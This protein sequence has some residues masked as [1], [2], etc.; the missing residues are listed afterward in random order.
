MIYADNVATTQL[1]KDA[2]DAMIPFMTRSMGMHRNHTPL[3]QIEKKALRD[4]R[5][6]IAECINAS[7]EE[8]FFTSGEQKV[9]IGH[10]KKWKSNIWGR[11]C[12]FAN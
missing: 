6:I 1:D 12:N 7:P 10:K 5:K 11:C 2:F 8:I 3:L 4:A 9:I